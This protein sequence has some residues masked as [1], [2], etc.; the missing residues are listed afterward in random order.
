MFSLSDSGFIQQVMPSNCL[1]LRKSEPW[2]VAKRKDKTKKFSRLLWSC[3]KTRSTEG[4]WR[5]PDDWWPTKH[6]LKSK[7][8]AVS[9]A[10]YA[11]DTILRKQEPCER[12]VPPR[13]TALRTWRPVTPQ[14]KLWGRGLSDF[15]PRQ[16]GEPSQCN[17]CVMP[18]MSKKQSWM[19]LYDTMYT[20]S[21]SCFY[22][23]KQW[24][25]RMVTTVMMWATRSSH[26]DTGSDLCLYTCSESFHSGSW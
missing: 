11:R 18:C 14:T 8:A 2:S 25:S 22:T 16:F 13:V 10:S 1:G 20:S 6:L 24:Q 23:V 4:L 15:S 19:M 12:Y 5:P 21:Q 9:Y 7:F 3:R 26:C 17:H